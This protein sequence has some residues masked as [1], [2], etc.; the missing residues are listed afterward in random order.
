VAGELVWTEALSTGIETID[1]QH[2]EIFDAVN[3]L[4]DAIEAGEGEKGTAEILAYLD[5]YVSHHFALEELH[6]LRHGYPG[7]GGHRK[8]HQDFA[9]DFLLLQETFR[10]GGAPPL[11]V[12]EVRIRVC[13]WLVE[14]IGHVDRALGAFLL[15]RRRG[16]EA[17][18]G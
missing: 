4:I 6:M 18:P 10:E 8:A 12:R 1:S 16:E 7:Y 2:R 3:S 13:E 15:A 5:G 11:L 17:P 9:E 14:H